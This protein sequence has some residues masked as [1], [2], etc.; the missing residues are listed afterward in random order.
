[1]DIKQIEEALKNEDAFLLT[2]Q[3]FEEKP[4]IDEV[5]EKL[6]EKLAGES[7]VRQGATATASGPKL[8]E[9]PPRG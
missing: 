7:V 5:I 9:R 8:R 2:L 3:S 6:E 1:V 4:S